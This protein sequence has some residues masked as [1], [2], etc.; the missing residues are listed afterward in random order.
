VA[1]ATRNL[2]LILKARDEASRVIKGF[3]RELTR[4]N[5]LARAE[6]LRNTAAQAALRAV[7]M[8]QTGAAQADI[9]AQRLM[10]RQLRAQA[11]ELERNHRG[12]IRLTNAMQTLS[13]TLVTVGSGLAIGGAAG[14]AILVK[15]AQINRD[16][17]KQVALT[18]TQ[19]DGFKTSLSE[20]SQ[21]G[22]DVA[23]NIAVPFQEIQPELYDIFSSTNAN[24]AQA[25]ILLEGFAKTAVAGDVS[26]Q[27]AT[28]GTIP[29]LNAF[30][31]PLT[32][33]NRILDIQ[34]QL[35]R[36]GV[37]TYGEFSKVFGRVVP[38]AT[39]AGQNFQTV[40]AML[41]FLTR[42][43][44]SAAMASTSAARALDAM[45][46]PAAIK[47]M[48]KLGISVRD[49]KGNF[50]P[51]N[52]Q[53]IHLR[54]Y[55]MKLPNKDRIAALVDIFKGAGGTIQAR[56]FLDQVLLKPGQ[57]EDYLG[58]LKD[59]NK[60][61][62]AFSRAYGQMADTISAK[63]QLIKNK[64]TVA[65]QAL[66]EAVT[67]LF[68][69]AL[70]YVAKLIDGF[71]NLSPATKRWI[72]V[73]LLL[74]S[75]LTILA[76]VVVVVLG[77]LA[78]LV[79]A[80]I[81]AGTP[82]FVLIG[83]IVGLTGAIVG[84][85]AAIAVAWE[86]S[87]TFRE[88]VSKLHDHIVELYTTAV[89][90]TMDAIQRDFNTKLL[91]IAQRVSKA[92]R[93]EIL[94]RLKELADFIWQKLL[95]AIQEVYNDIKDKLGWIMSWL[96]WMINN[97]VIPAVKDLSKF[98]RDHKETIDQMIVV[99]I[100][101][102]KWIVRIGLTIAALAL[103]VG[104]SVLIGAFILFI[105]VIETVGSAI[106]TTWENV[107]KFIDVI[108]GAGNSVHIS[109]VKIKQAIDSIA[110]YFDSLPSRIKAAVGN[111][112]TLLLDAGKSIIDGLINGI[113]AKL[114]PLGSVIAGAAQLIKDHFPHS[115]AKTGPL[116]GTGGMF[117]AGQNMMR[118]LV[119]GMS[120]VRVGDAAISGSARAGRLL[121][122]GVPGRATGGL[123]QEIHIHTQELN[124]VRQAAE[125][126]FLLAART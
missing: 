103:I 24:V 55:L 74:V 9:D 33:V 47:H 120:S 126:G 87:K 98:Y 22:L 53:L 62:G 17:A 10:A 104:G 30:K 121:A 25:K 99:A 69:K 16:Y 63:S 67:P 5:A 48:E 82:F 64:F 49:L 20:L 28:R 1:I 31:I 11:Q 81:T 12:V 61:N 45:S 40:A 68:L 102:I 4:A 38:S 6:Q 2:Y 124:P 109:K 37:G 50:L 114:G 110:G 86:R 80:V 19:V 52:E 105:G 13:A 108:T 107:K 89:K 76:G 29:I 18:I 26:L 125:L 57:L 72:A 112:G 97:V 118:Q 58:F 35:V 75:T 7:E 65:M 79:A 34:F 92:F 119:Q 88:E 90:P 78:G 43:G 56:R 85:G 94:P 21:V 116:S 39:R 122:G 101:L 96:A 59:M 83:A 70:T 44:L 77:V 111:L 123:R 23:K 100:W 36:K 15:A 42:N 95:P 41:A 3:G 54:T 93:D 60:A 14:I 115:P 66:G 8:E 84:F 46:N 113:K 91:P 73:G 27:D 51:L 106:V 117:Y 32:D 71:N